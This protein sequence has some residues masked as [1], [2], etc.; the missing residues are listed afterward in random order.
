MG[1]AMINSHIAN[2]LRE[3]VVEDE[4]NLDFYLIH[5]NIL[6]VCSPYDKTSIVIQISLLYRLCGS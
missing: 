4:Y 2:P 3:E 5:I 1:F 6:L